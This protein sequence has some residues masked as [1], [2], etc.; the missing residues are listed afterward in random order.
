MVYGNHDVAR[1]KYYRYEEEQLLEEPDNIQHVLPRFI[2]PVTNAQL[3]EFN[4][5]FDVLVESVNK[6]VEI[7]HN[8]FQHILRLQFV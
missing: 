6:G 1:P 3:N 8:M 7:Y 5:T 2:L 4:N